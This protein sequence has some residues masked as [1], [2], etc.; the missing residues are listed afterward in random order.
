M[1]INF[2]KFLNSTL[3]TIHITHNTDSMVLLSEM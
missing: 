1:K 2:L 3:A